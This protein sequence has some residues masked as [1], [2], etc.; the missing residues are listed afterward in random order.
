MPPPIRGSDVFIAEDVLRMMRAVSAT[1][2]AV[3]RVSGGGGGE[4]AKGYSDGFTDGIRAL[5]ESM[6][7]QFMPGR[8]NTSIGVRWDG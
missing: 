5:A 6:G 4:Y 7:I 1:H 2:E 3:R 8:G